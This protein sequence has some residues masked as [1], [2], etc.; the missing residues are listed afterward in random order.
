MRELCKS[1][2]P[3]IPVAFERN[4]L[5]ALIPGM[6][7]SA[8][9]LGQ[10]SVV[11]PLKINRSAEQLWYDYPKCVEPVERVPLNLYFLWEPPALLGPKWMLRL[12]LGNVMVRFSSLFSCTFLTLH[13]RST[14]SPVYFA[15]R[16][17]RRRQCSTNAKGEDSPSFVLFAKIER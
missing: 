10:T 8:S 16:D 15:R 11:S 4:N 12:R 1:V 3:L 5:H 7:D 6:A 17:D 14:S 13:N 9:L 2:S